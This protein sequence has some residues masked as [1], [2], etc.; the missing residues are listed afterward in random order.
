MS[1]YVKYEEYY[2]Y[3]PK[4][5][6][7]STNTSSTARKY[8]LKFAY[9]ALPTDRKALPALG[10][11]PHHPVSHFVLLLDRRLVLSARSSSGGIP[12][13]DLASPDHPIKTKQELVQERGES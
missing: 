3:L 9:L 12:L 4:T 13:L 5:G 7:V 11:G 6:V 1:A 2:I 8:R 10:E